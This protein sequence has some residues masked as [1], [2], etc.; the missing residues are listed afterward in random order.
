MH[1]ER[2]IPVL[3][4]PG[5]M[6]LKLRYDDP[7]PNFP[8][9]FNWRRFNLAAARAAAAGTHRWCSPRHRMPFDS[10]TEGSKCI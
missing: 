1:V 7:L 6:L 2:M 10:R 8:F 9:N 3:K 4:A 5:P